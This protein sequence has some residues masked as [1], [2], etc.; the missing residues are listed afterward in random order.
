MNVFLKVEY[1]TIRFLPRIRQ[2]VS[3]VRRMGV[4]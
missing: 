3:V 4:K 2:L 1:S